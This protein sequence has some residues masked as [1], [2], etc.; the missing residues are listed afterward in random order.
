MNDGTS[1]KAALYKVQLC[2]P[3]CDVSSWNSLQR[4][5]LTRFDTNVFMFW[6][7]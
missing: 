4:N 6:V 7:W 1:Y 5:L 3:I 2:P